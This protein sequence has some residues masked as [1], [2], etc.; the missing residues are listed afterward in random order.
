MIYEEKRKSFSKRRLVLLWSIAFMT[1]IGFSA[2]KKDAD[3]IDPGAFVGTWYLTYY[4]EDENRN[5]VNDDAKMPLQFYESY[6]IVFRNDGKVQVHSQPDQSTT[7]D[8]TYDWSVNTAGD[9]T[10]HFTAAGTSASGIDKYDIPVAAL[11]Y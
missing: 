7:F 10:L 8:Q 1:Y 4:M 9:I 2:C 3:G 5:S 11:S 6:A